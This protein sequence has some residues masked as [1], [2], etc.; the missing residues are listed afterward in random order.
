MDLRGKRALVTG[1][2]VRIGRAIVE[3]L[4]AEGCD[5]VIHYWRSAAAAQ[6]LARAIRARG[7]Q[8]WTARSRLTGAADCERLIAGA[9][10][11]AGGLEILINNAAVFRKFDLAAST[12]RRLLAELRV[13]ALAPILLTRAFARLR[14]A[15][16]SGAA[17][18]A[19]VVNLLD[20]RVAGV[21]AGC[22]PYLL[23][24]KL[25]AEF[26]RV[27]ALEL[28]PHIAVNGVAPGPI[29]PPPGGPRRIADRA[30]RRPLAAPLTPRDVAAAVVYLLQSDA[31]TGQILFV[32]GGQHLRPPPLP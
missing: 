30:G 18:A 29:L 11:R 12:E 15:P 26:T 10:R 2:A 20:R 5:V 27:A 31:L 24:K 17:P 19:K 8:A 28:A 22:L 3:T 23:S 13:N 32:D 21:E 9:A 14:R 25:L 4:A 1:G 6:R 16:A 7:G